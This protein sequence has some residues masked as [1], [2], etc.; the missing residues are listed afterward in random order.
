MS[1]NR[2]K[3]PSHFTQ[4]QGDVYMFIILFNQKFKTNR[5]SVYDHKR[6]RKAA[7]P[8]N[9]EA[10]TRKFLVFFFY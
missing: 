3:C 10:G 2:K 4:G 6:Q 5:C 9:L 1:E 7:D 8:N